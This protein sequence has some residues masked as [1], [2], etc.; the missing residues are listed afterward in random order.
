MDYSVLVLAVLLAEILL[1]HIGEHSGSHRGGRI[2][3]RDT[4]INK[5][6]DID[7]AVLTNNHIIS[8]IIC[9]ASIPHYPAMPGYSP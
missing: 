7:C 4:T 1:H 9:L 3:D 2:P 5:T 8:S 6:D